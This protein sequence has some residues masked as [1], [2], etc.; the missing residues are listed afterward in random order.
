ML[1]RAEKTDAEIKH[2][3]SIL[4]C[5][6]K[7]RLIADWFDASD[8]LKGFIG[9]R[10]VQRELRKWATDISDVLRKGERHD[11]RAPRRV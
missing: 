11:R 5:P 7:L 9:D 4:P 3:K 2:I 6:N 8:N 10:E 1:T